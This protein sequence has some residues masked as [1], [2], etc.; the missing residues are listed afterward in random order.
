[1]STN[2]VSPESARGLESSAA[3]AEPGSSLLSLLERRRSIR[4]LE[5]GP[6][7]QE[8][9]E[10]IL[11]AIR[12]TPAAF[13]LPSWHVV[14]VHDEREAFWDVVEAGFR[15]KLEGDR[16]ERYLNRLE[17]FR[18]GVAIALIYEDLTVR[19][20]LAD[21]F[22]V[23]L[24]QAT[25]FAEQGLGMVQLALWLELTAE[26]LVTSLQHWDW[27][28]EKELAAHLE[29]PEEHYRLIA[30]MPIGYAAEPPRATEKPAIERIVSRDRFSG[31]RASS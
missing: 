7:D 4:R 11:E 31:N 2:G 24:A 8:M 9:Q 22:Q 16:L 20:Q 10:R 12:L 27:L 3:V 23:S 28:L 6:F 25:S 19:Q 29:L 21:G 5:S 26:G 14:L 1:M 13:S 18:G 17:G 30:V 15:A